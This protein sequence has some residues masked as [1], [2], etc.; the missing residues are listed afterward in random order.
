M[1]LCKCIDV[2][3]GQLFELTPLF[4]SLTGYCERLI[5][6]KGCIKPEQCGTDV[7]THYL[8]EPTEGK[9]GRWEIHD[10]KILLK[11][12]G[13]I[14]QEKVLRALLSYEVLNKKSKCR[15]CIGLCQIS[16]EFGERHPGQRAAA[17]ALVEPTTPELD[18]RNKELIDRL[19]E[20]LDAESK[21]ILDSYLTGAS[22]VE[23][24]SVLNIS[25]CAARQRV[26][27]IKRSLR[28][29]LKKLGYGKD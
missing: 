19:R 8:F 17:R 4:Y 9:K 2:A 13:A 28:E 27:R 25:G 21:N 26:T 12:S 20:N 29:T 6:P 18:L 7:V 23:I 16:D 22:S 5:R 11:I 24:A 14:S 15:D 10:D 1:P 3:D